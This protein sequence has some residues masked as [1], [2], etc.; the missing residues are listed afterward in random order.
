MASFLRLAFIVQAVPKDYSGGG[1][2]HGAATPVDFWCMVEAAVGTLAICLPP[3]A[4]LLRWNALKARTMATSAAA[5]SR[6]ETNFSARPSLSQLEKGATESR[7]GSL[8]DAT[9]RRGGRGLREPSESC[10]TEEL[11]F[12]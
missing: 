8:S 1:N 2:K 12:R 3:L 11:M 10:L 6:K 9:P 5:L 4:P 7:T